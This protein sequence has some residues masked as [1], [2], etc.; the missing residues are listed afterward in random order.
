MTTEQVLPPWG[1]DHLSSLFQAAE[2]NDRIT[3]LNF[4]HIYRLLQR[5]DA[6][7]IRIGEAVEKD[8]REELLVPR[9][10]IARTLPSFFASIRL[11]MSGQVPE[12]YPVLRSGIEQAWYALHIAKDPHPPDRVKMWLCRNDDESSKSKCRNE[13]KV[14]NARSTHQSFDSA[15]AKQV[16]ELYERVIDLGA[17]PNQQGV[18]SAMNL[19]EAEEETTCQVGLILPKV[20]TVLIALK[21]AMEVAIGTFKVYQLIFPER[22]KIM[23][24][25]EEI[26]TIVG[27]L[28]RAFKP[29][30]SQLKQQE[31]N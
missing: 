25:D 19:S 2:D 4:P 18:L 14:E 23:S 20:I 8:S 9:I 21:T 15:T 7:F 10:L 22:F 1:N 16:H 3:S 11:A 5:I 27:E 6:A 31:G 28:N 29:Y 30:V 24:L 26:E 12:S 13:F 17:H